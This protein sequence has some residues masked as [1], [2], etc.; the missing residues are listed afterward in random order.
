[1]RKYLWPGHFLLW[2]Q[3]VPTVNHFL[4]FSQA[5]NA[6]VRKMEGVKLLLCT[7]RL[8]ISEPCYY[9][10]SPWRA[11]AEE[12]LARER[13]RSHSWV[14]AASVLFKEGRAQKS[15]SLLLSLAESAHPTLWLIWTWKETLQS[16]MNNPRQLL[17]RPTSKGFHS[18]F[19]K[20]NHSFQVIS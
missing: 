8:I 16:A 6:S 12:V 9:F 10:I 7:V 18:A 11:L 1:M 19:L 20:C 5:S 14:S 17:I 4:P 15:L 2:G 3:A 13:S